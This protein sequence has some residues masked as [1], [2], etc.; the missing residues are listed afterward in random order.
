MVEATSVRPYRRCPA[1]RRGPWRTYRQGSG[2]PG[3]IARTRSEAFAPA[4][5]VKWV[6]W[7]ESTTTVNRA[8]ASDPVTVA[9]RYADPPSGLP[10]VAKVEASGQ[11]FS[12]AAIPAVASVGGVTS[13]AR[14]VGVNDLPWPRS[15]A[16]QA[17][18]LVI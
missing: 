17:L 16:S 7:F 9:Q 15:V 2:S 3:S 4:E 1:G 5:S 10:N 13:T 18:M 11:G 14:L 8:A 6:S 12:L